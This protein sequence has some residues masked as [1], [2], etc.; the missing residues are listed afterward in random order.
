VKNQI[1]E[2]VK[3]VSSTHVFFAV[4]ADGIRSLSKV[5][6]FE[7]KNV[8]R[9][10]LDLSL[11][12]VEHIDNRVW[13]VWLHVVKIVIKRAIQQRSNDDN[14]TRDGEMSYIAFDEFKAFC[15]REVLDNMRKQ[16][17]IVLLFVLF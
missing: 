6:V 7:V 15:E 17:D 2:G 14:E 5:N 11:I 16:Q 1:Y 8:S 13:R 10:D 9:I 12:A 3:S 4:E